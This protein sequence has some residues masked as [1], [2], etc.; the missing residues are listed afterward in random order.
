MNTF[1]AAIDPTTELA[2][3][4]RQEA[5]WTF[6]QGSMD[7]LRR[8]DTDPKAKGRYSTLMASFLFGDKLLEL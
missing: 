7:D 1:L 4:V 5:D 3:L 8:A 6:V 2:I